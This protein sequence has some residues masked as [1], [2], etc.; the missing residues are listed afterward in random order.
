[1]TTNTATVL[2]DLFAA[3]E[4]SGFGEAF[5]DRLSDDVVFTATGTSPVAGKYHGKTE[6]REKV[7]SRLHD[8]LATPMRPH[9]DH[10]IIDGEW[11]AVRFHTENVVGVNGTDAGMQYCWVIRVTDD[12]ITEVIGYYDTEKMVGLF[13]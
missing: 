8:R 10:M 9:V 12:H 11:A 2:R 1:M 6:Y 4:Q 13:A 5:L 3:A 7:L